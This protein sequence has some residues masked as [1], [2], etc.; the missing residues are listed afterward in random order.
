[1]SEFDYANAPV[2]IDYLINSGLLFHINSHVLHPVGISFVVKVNKD[3]VKSLELK[4]SRSE[5]EKMI[6]N[7]NT[8]DAG[9]AKY[10]KFTR[11]Y[12]FK[13]MEIRQD[14]LGFGVQFNS[15]NDK[16]ISPS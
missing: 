7:G 4:D 13:Q 8:F 16:G 3:G 14:K 12:G 10:L 1:M 2:D 15:P 5:P 6:F 11:H 9:Y